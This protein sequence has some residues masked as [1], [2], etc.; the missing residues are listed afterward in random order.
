MIIILVIYV[1]ILPFF[2]ASPGS[3]SVFERYRN[4]TS[5][6]AVMTIIISLAASVLY[7]SEYTQNTMK[8]I[9][10]YFNRRQVFFTKLVV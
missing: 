8:N 9:V 3:Y 4:I 1:A 6:I 7:A 2:I 5:D 10:Q